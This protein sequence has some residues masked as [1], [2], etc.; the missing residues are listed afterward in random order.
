MSGKIG[1]FEKDTKKHPTRWYS[2]RQEKT[3]ARELG[4][5]QTPNSGATT[6]IKGDVNIGSDWL[7][8]A[9]TKTTSTESF[10][11]KKEWLEKNLSESISM[12]KKHNALAFNY[13]PDT[14]NYY[15]VDE[16]TFKLLISALREIE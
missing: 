5:K 14:D 9:K 7:I 6:F 1:L 2:N 13:G 3:I 11:I 4:G 15:I 12:C 8:E 16:R 10:S